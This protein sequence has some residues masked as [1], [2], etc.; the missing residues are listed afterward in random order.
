[1][2]IVFTGVSS[3]VKIS[4]CLLFLWFCC[5]AVNADELHLIV[6]GKSIHFGTDTSFN[7]QNWGLGFEYDF[8]ERNN[9]IPLITGAS[10][11]D[12][13]ENTSNYI[14]GGSK[15]RFLLGDDPEGLHVDA[16]VIGFVM[17]RQDYKNND[18]F[19]GALP[20]I[21]VG[22]SRFAVNIIYVPEIVPKMVAFVYFQAT[23]KLAEF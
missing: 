1:M 23:F 13:L 8:K 18:P 15:R 22:N 19:L 20:F 10:F 4:Y 11:K 9:W 17:T 16:G 12:S 14:G 3:R 21:S 7:E 6:S 5:A 2:L